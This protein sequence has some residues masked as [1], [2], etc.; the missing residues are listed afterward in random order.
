[1]AGNGFITRG[2]TLLAIGLTLAC[3]GCEPPTVAVEETPI[4]VAG[5]REGRGRAASPGDVVCIDYRVLMPDGSE[6]MRDRNFCFQLGGGAVI[7][8]LDDGVVGMRR[9]GR[10][11][12]KCPPHKHWGRAGYGNGAVPP[13]T[14]L[15]LHVELKS[16][17]EGPGDA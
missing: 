9:G 8:G 4:T 16:I 7:A 5:E 15:T 17:D 14:T 11:V 6:L 12:I 13:N 2:R 10:R 3:L 1:M